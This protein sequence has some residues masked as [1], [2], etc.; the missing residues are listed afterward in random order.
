MFVTAIGLEHTGH[1]VWWGD[2]P[3]VRD[4]VF[5]RLPG[6]MLAYEASATMY[7]MFWQQLAFE[8]SRRNRS[9]AILRLTKALR[10]NHHPGA[11]MWTTMNS[12]PGGRCHVRGGIC[13]TPDVRLLWQSARL[14]AVEMRFLL[15]TR[16]AFEVIYDRMW[17][18]TGYVQERLDLLTRSCR[19]M[20]HQLAVLPRSHVFCVPYHDTCN[21]TARLARLDT[22]LDAP[23]ASEVLCGRFR[24]T[25]RLRPPVP[26]ALYAKF[27]TFASCATRVEDDFC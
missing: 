3:R 26:P 24:K 7:G 5:G 1:H 14:A 27:Q 4:G 6:Y 10:D 8:S 23:R 13:S 12:Y 17:L 2:E 9:S 19:R 25:R 18:N 20:Q 11:R 15:L 16:P 22:F 21:N